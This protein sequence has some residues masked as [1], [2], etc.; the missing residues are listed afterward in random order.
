MD[1]SA[2]V[3]DSAREA[4]GDVDPPRLRRELLD[5]IDDAWLVPGTLTVLVARKAGANGV[6]AGLSSRAV[7]VQLIYEGLSLTR[8]LVHDE[9]WSDGDE[10]QADLEVLVADVL[11]ARGAYLLART[12]AADHA[13]ELIRA[14][15]RDQSGRPTG[16]PGHALEEDV[17]ELAA[18]AGSTYVGD[19]PDAPLVEWA[20][21][22]ADSLGDGDHP[23][24]A[25]LLGRVEATGPGGQTAVANEGRT[26]SSDP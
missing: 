13:V 9:P 20:D 2:E 25:T 14:F 8:G 22:L 6:S 5:H 12:E 11:V 10:E 17:F 1:D 24:V 19:D 4:L 18:V 16:E 15:G 21:D 3:R 7:G 23:D 26:G